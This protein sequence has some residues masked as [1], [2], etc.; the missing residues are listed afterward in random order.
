MKFYVCTKYFA[1]SVYMFYAQLSHLV[2]HPTAGIS[3][4]YTGKPNHGLDSGSDT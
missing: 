4:Y 3:P 1:S 2:A